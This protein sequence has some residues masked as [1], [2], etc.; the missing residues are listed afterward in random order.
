MRVIDDLHICLLHHLIKRTSN[1]EKDL[2]WIL[3]KS[4]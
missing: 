2:N 1:F 4:T 3:V